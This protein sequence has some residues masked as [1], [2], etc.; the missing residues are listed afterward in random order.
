MTAQHL[1]LLLGPSGKTR[2]LFPYHSNTYRHAP[3][4]ENVAKVSLPAHP[5]RGRPSPRNRDTHQDILAEG[6]GRS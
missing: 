6:P 2:I 3:Q 5:L 1:A 4:P